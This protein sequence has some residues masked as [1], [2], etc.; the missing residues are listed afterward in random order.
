MFGALGR[1]TSYA[2]GKSREPGKSWYTTVRS[3]KHRYFTRTEGP[4]LVVTARKKTASK[5]AI[6]LVEATATPILCI[7]NSILHHIQCTHEANIFNCRRS[8]MCGKAISTT[9]ICQANLGTQ[10]IRHP[11]TSHSG[12]NGRNLDL[13]LPT[14]NH[15]F[16]I[17][18]GCILQKWT[19]FLHID[20]R[21]GYS[22]R[23][24]G[25]IER[26]STLRGL[27]LCAWMRVEGPP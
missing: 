20:R 18:P 10:A 16:P 8:K 1:T 2:E 27:K 13:A 19:K 23:K 17:G 21:S 7:R 6:A 9:V 25:S 22:M 4:D 12:T 3:N 15:N 26:C 14:P 11:C 5:I 24:G